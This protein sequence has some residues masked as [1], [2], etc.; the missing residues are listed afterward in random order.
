MRLQDPN[1]WLPIIARGASHLLEA[2]SAA[3]VM[4]STAPA[5]PARRPSPNVTPTSSPRPPRYER[6]QQLALLLC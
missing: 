3:K 1:Q 4:S 2:Q 5:V 6:H